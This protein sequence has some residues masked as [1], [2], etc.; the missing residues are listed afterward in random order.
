MLSPGFVKILR[1]LKAK[2]QNQTVKKQNQTVKKQKKKKNL[3][4]S[5]KD[6]FILQIQEVT[7]RVKNLH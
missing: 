6:I 1:H 3:R 2:Q 7:Q 5:E 4:D